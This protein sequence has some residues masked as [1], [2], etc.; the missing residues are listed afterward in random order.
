M[1]R[2]KTTNRLMSLLTAAGLFLTV[3]FTFKGWTGSW[4]PGL[5]EVSASIAPDQTDLTAP[6]RCER[7]IE[8]V[9]VGDRVLTTA[10]TSVKSQPTA[11]NPRTWR[12]L[13]LRATLYWDDG[14]RDEMRVE[15]LQPCNWI[16]KYQ[17]SVGTQVPLP[18]DLVEM[19]LPADLQATV[20]AIEP[21]PEIRDGPGQVVLTTVSHLNAEL[22]DL[23]VRDA[24]GSQQTIGV[25]AHHKIYAATTESWVAA[26]DLTIGDTLV[27]LNCPVVVQQLQ[28][29]TGTERVYNLTVEHEHVYRVGHDAILVHNNCGKGASRG[30]TRFITN[31]DGKTV[32]LGPTLDRISR[33][34]RF[35]HR[36]DGSIFRNREGRLPSKPDGYYREYV[37][38]TPGT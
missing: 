20:Q 10:T 29:R 36:N 27:G 23:T 38:P 2:S 11:V 15:T 1:A 8:Q 28:R 7:P 19:G 13:R 33:G 37:H 9:R 5:P 34:E 24:T 4:V 12:K 35:P 17:A 22:F 6:S 14:T 25:T 21:C 30:T 16:A 3:A 26:R 31:P 18:L 32:D